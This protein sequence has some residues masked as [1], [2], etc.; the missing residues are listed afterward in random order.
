[1]RFQKTIAINAAGIQE[2][3]ETGALKLQRGQWVQCNELTPDSPK[4]RYI[5]QMEGGVIWVAHWQGSPKATREHFQ[6]C[7]EAMQGRKA[8]GA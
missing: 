3:L 7:V 4:A 8:I 6:T 2:A 5:G 1:M